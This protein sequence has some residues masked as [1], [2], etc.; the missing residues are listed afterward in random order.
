MKKDVQAESLLWAWVTLSGIVKNS[1]ITKGLQYN[2]AIIMNVIHRR[3]LE[4]GEGIVS[5][6]EITQ[7]TR[8][9]KSLVNRTLNSLI[10]KGFVLRCEGEGD[11][12]VAYVKCAKEKLETFLKVHRGSIM[13]A[14]KIIDIIG[15]EDAKAFI[16]IVN[17]IEKS[18]YNLD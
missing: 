7:K 18:G 5:V 16:R 8:M 2:E 3:F 6:K 17:K 13:H 1:R 9:L 11:K 14:E 12:R 15:E 4:D 10:K